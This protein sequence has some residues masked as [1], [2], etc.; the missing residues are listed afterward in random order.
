M[1]VHGAHTRRMTNG[2]KIFVGNSERN[3]KLVM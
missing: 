3:M 1:A 2:Y